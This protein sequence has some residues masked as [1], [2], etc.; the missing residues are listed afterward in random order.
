MDSGE[1]EIKDEPRIETP[2]R[3]VTVFEYGASGGVMI[4]EEIMVAFEIE[5]GSQVR[6]FTQTSAS[7]KVL[8]L[9]K[10]E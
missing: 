1:R 8:V 2:G 5:K 9:R 10:D 4:P 7:G 6:W 3:K